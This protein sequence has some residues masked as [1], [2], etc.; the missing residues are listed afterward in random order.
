MC[1]HPQLVV[2]LAV[3]CPDAEF[4]ASTNTD[5]IALPQAHCAFGDCTEAV[6]FD[7]VGLRRVLTVDVELHDDAIAVPRTKGSVG[8]TTGKHDDVHDNPL[9]PTG[10]PGHLATKSLT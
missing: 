2:F 3:L 7:P 9:P 5:Q 1:H 8:D 10:T 6:Q 4:D